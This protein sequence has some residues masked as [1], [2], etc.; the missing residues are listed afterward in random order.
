[1][2]PRFLWLG[3]L[4]VSLWACTPDEEVFS[5]LSDERLFFSTDTLFFDTLL[6][7][8]QSPS[9]RA[10]LFNPNKNGVIVPS[11][12]LTSLSDSPYELTINGLSGKSFSN[13]KILGG[14]SLLILVK[15]TLPPTGS[16][17]PELSRDYIEIAGNTEN[18][19]IDAWGQDATFLTG[20]NVILGNVVWDSPLP[21]VISDTLLVTADAI[22]T[23]LEG[24]EVVM[25]PG[26]GFF[27]A[28]SLLTEGSPESKVVF[29]NDRSDRD[30]SEAP[31][32]WEG[33]FFLE[34]SK[35]NFLDHTII[36]NA[37]IGLY[38]GTPDDDDTPDVTLSNCLIANMAS[39]GILAFTS[40][41]YA[42]NTVVYNA[43]RYLLGNLAGG[44]YRYEH[45]TFTNYPSDFFRDGPAVV[46]SDNILLDDLTL[47]TAP[48][49][50]SV[51]GSIIWGSEQEE[52][53]LNTEGGSSF[54]VQMGYSVLKTKRAIFDVNN[55]LL[56]IN[57]QF[58]NEFLYDYRPDSL[59]PL[60]NAATYLNIDLD[61]QGLPRDSLP[62]IGAYEWTPGQK[63]Q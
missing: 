61:V 55:N 20:L 9:Y 30:Y 35:G 36:K 47:L 34:G 52:I 3:V 8:K 59:S 33:I 7:T 25:R 14:D 2:L 32:Q 22:L 6:T 56:N 49:Q 62:D 18:V 13:V 10:L 41:V 5:E 31:G 1:M 60:I 53:E 45:C 63:N 58:Y 17:S 11:I 19:V 43:G 38:I 23:I 16:A 57:P 24:V 50:A 40:D 12:A 4:I 46:F 44:N 51:F 42:Y 29:R 37:N 21:Y 54:L 28:G 39:D 15:A 26:S 48:L 27:V